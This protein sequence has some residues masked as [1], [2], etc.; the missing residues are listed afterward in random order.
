MIKILTSEGT[1][2]DLVKG[3][4][5]EIEYNNPMFDDTRMPVP[6]STQIDL[7]PTATNCKVLSWLPALKMAPGVKRLAVSLNLNGIDFI[8]GTLIFDSIEDGRACYTFAGRDIEDDWGEKLW[9]YK[10]GIWAITQFKTSGVSAFQD[11][12]QSN[13]IVWPLIV[14]KEF[15]GHYVN[16]HDDISYETSEDNEPG[17]N[18]EA[19]YW[20]PCNVIPESRCGHIMP[21]IL[22]SKI[23]SERGVSASGLDKYMKHICLLAPFDTDRLYNDGESIYAGEHCPDIS[24]A[25]FYKNIAYMFCAAIFP[26]D[27]RLGYHKMVPFDAMIGYDDWTEK[28][29]DDFSSS[30]EYGKN[31]SI[32][33]N[34]SDEEDK[35]ADPG[36]ID[37]TSIKASLFPSP[38]PD[39]SGQNKS[40]TQIYTGRAPFPGKSLISTKTMFRN[41]AKHINSTSSAYTRHYA[42]TAATDCLYSRNFKFSSQQA[43]TDESEDVSIAFDLPKCAPQILNNYALYSISSNQKVLDSIIQR[44]SLAAIIEASENDE[45]RPTTPIIGVY[46]NGQMSPDGISLRTSIQTP[47]PSNATVRNYTDVD[48]TSSDSAVVSLL[49]M[50]LFNK[51][52]KNYAEWCAKDKQVIVCD[53]N[54]NEFDLASIDFSRKARIHGR[55]FFIRKITVT[56]NEATEQLACSAEFISC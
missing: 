56:I 49:P 54:L 48:G 20:N 40:Y 41:Y 9:K 26:D 1:S 13:G 43:A 45:T 51:F 23:F 21:A 4:E 29:T 37:L 30:L 33:F 2:L 46:H 24:F 32:G 5:F 15:T 17:V 39:L 11:Y 19:K 35:S 31:Y 38:V 44:C 18:I 16:G 47:A 53:V 55:D 6:F 34:N 14:N 50:D 25:E 28:V 22:A 7:L 36:I 8:K 10:N 27:Q 52:H 3:C 12:S 42:A